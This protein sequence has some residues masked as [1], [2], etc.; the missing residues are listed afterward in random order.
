MQWVLQPPIVPSCPLACCTF[1]QQKHVSPFSSLPSRTAAIPALGMLIN[2]RSNFG[3]AVNGAA[4][5]RSVSP[6]TSHTSAP[7]HSN[8]SLPLFPPDCSAAC[9]PLPGGG[10]WDPG[11]RS[12]SLPCRSPSLPACPEASHVTTPCL[13]FPNWVNGVAAGG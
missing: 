4:L 3:H 11:Q 7:S 13:S 5:G 12:R 8:F 9:I 2:R 10:R 1:A 6:S